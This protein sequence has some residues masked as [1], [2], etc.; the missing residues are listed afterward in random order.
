MYKNKETYEYFN[1]RNVKIRLQDAPVF[2]TSKPHYENTNGMSITIDQLNRIDLM[3][4]YVTLRHK[5][6]LRSS[7]KLVFNCIMI[8]QSVF[9]HR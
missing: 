6:D 9:E 2:V 4:M 7:G 1:D 5:I 3:K 8:Q